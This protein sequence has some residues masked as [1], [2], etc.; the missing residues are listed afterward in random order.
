MKWHFECG[1]LTANP[2]YPDLK[3]WLKALHFWDIKNSSTV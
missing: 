3:I 2:Q 1:Y